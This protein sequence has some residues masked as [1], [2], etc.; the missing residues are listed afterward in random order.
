[1]AE[2][3]VKPLPTSSSLASIVLGSTHSWAFSRIFVQCPVLTEVAGVVPMESGL[4][5]NGSD[6]GK[7]WRRSIN[8]LRSLAMAN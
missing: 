2:R 5:N 3:G 6:G 8:L 1:M 4:A 7:F